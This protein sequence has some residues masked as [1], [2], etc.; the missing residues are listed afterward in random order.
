METGSL[1]IGDLAIH[2]VLSHVHK[3]GNHSVTGGNLGTCT[4]YVSPNFSD[5]WEYHGHL[6][7]IHKGVKIMNKDDF[8]KELMEEEL[9]K[10]KGRVITQRIIDRL[11]LLYSPLFDREYLTSIA[12]KVNREHQGNKSDKPADGQTYKEHRLFDD[13]DMGGEKTGLAP[14]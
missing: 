2:D 13:L 1:T 8:A 3:E 4:C 14:A 12:E 7:S 10:E 11:V 6:Y 9:T 5:W